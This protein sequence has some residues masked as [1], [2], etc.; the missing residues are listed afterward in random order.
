MVISLIR[1]IPIPEKREAILLILESM[2]PATLAKPGCIECGVY[3]EYDADR[4]ILYSEQWLS[5]EELNRHIQSGLYLRVLTAIDLAK[6]QPQVCFHHVSNTDC[7]SLIEAL[8]S[9]SGNPN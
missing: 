5:E 2:I 6:N 1:L 8:R 3:E 7:E 4:S 9:E